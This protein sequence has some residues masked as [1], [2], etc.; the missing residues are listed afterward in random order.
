M[1]NPFA[2]FYT[3]AMAP[4]DRLGGKLVPSIT[5]RAASLADMY[6][7]I[8]PGNGG[9]LTSRKVRTVPIDEL[10]GNPTSIYSQMNANDLV[11]N[12][13]GATGTARPTTIDAANPIDAYRLG[14]TV[15]P[16]ANP[17]VSAI[18]SAAPSLASMFGSSFRG[19]W[20]SDGYVLPGMN[21]TEAN[22]MPIDNGRPLNLPGGGGVRS[23]APVAAA[24]PPKTPMQSLADM[25]TPAKVNPNITYDQSA[26]RHGGHTSTGEDNS[27]M[28]R[29][30]QMSSRWNT[31]Y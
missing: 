12:V 7:D 28:P 15:G 30:V 31:G 22:G 10:T 21:Q 1:A 19:A 16:P 3:G 20:G 29:S 4:P 8:L 27:F 14:L 9:G 6:R 11:T 24:P 25:F 26:P 5:P 2:D 18:E 23:S 17:A 13:P